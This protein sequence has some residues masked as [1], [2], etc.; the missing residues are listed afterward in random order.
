MA[1]VT[2]TKARHMTPVAYEVIVRGYLAGAVTAG[3]P[4]VEGSTGWTKAATTDVTAHGI[5]L[6]DGAAGETIDV[7]KL[8][9]LELIGNNLVRGTAYYPSGS[10]AGGIDDTAPTFYSAATTPA[11]AVPVFPQMR[12]TWRGSATGGHLVLSYNFLP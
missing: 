7:G 1:A 3:M 8:G 4:L 5:A 11:V 6:Q 10:T 2:F 12:A 9:E